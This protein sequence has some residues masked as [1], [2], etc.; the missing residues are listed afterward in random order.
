MSER[1]GKERER[2]REEENERKRKRER[3]RDDG[4]YQGRSGKA[5][6][7]FNAGGWGW[8]E[9]ESNLAVESGVSYHLTSQTENKTPASQK[10]LIMQ[11]VKQIHSKRKGKKKKKRQRSNGSAYSAPIYHGPI[12]QINVL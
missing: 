10:L 1:R 8:R 4:L 5:M 2:E 7:I 11:F 9:G 3:E 6:L 12:Q